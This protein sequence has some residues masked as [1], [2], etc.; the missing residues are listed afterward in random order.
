MSKRTN[1]AAVTGDL[2][3]ALNRHLASPIETLKA[4]IPEPTHILPGAGRYQDDHVIILEVTETL[5]HVLYC[6]FA[7][8]FKHDWVKAETLIPIIKPTPG[9]SNPAAEPKDELPAFEQRVSPVVYEGAKEPVPD[10]DAGLK[11]DGR[12]LV[13]FTIPASWAARVSWAKV[14]KEVFGIFFGDY[15]K[16]KPLTITCR[17]D[18][19]GRFAVLMEQ[20]N[21]DPLQARIIPASD[22]TNIIDVTGR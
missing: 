6:R 18:Q 19:Y 22:R 14:L 5:A 16:S 9:C 3:E 4:Y 7:G 10:S 13:Q 21:K 20:A 12:D 15:D 11:Q 2:S 8:Q 17:L 1:D